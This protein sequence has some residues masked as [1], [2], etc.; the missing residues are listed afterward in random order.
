MIFDMLQSVSVDVLE[1][2]Y[3]IG[4]I[5][6][7]DNLFWRVLGFDILK[8]TFNQIHMELL[9]HSFIDLVWR[10]TKAKPEGGVSF[11]IHQV[12]ILAVKL[13]VGASH[14]LV[15]WAF[16]IIS[17]CALLEVAEK[18]YILYE[19]HYPHQLRLEDVKGDTIICLL[20]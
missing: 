19:F 6:Q 9:T 12:S 16:F 17:N 8:L 11:L 20:V 10:G 7:L 3:L 1:V 14:L 5:S 2:E 13:D 15:E 18:P 4:K